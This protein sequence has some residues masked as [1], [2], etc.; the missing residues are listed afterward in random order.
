MAGTRRNAAQFFKS[1]AAKGARTWPGRKPT[2]KG[3][4]GSRA[5]H[6]AGYQYLGI[7]VAGMGN[8]ASVS[9]SDS[10]VPRS[11]LEARDATE[12]RHE[13][14]RGAPAM[15]EASP[16]TETTLETPDEAAPRSLAHR[17]S[18]Q[19]RVDNIVGRVLAHKD[20]SMLSPGGDRTIS[21][22][23]PVDQESAHSDTPQQK[24]ASPDDFIEAHHHE[25][26]VK[27][28]KDP[29]ATP[30]DSQPCEEFSP[31]QRGRDRGD[32]PGDSD[33]Q[34]RRQESRSCGESG[35]EV[36]SSQSYTDSGESGDNPSDDTFYEPEVSS[37]WVSGKSRGR[38][39]TLHGEVSTPNGSA[40]TLALPRLHRRRRLYHD[41][42][43]PFGMSGATARAKPPNILEPRLGTFGFQERRRRP[44][45]DTLV[46]T[47]LRQGRHVERG[48]G[49]VRE[50]PS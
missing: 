6:L 5:E 37:V 32:S 27:G 7:V 3:D 28:G 44:G 11:R 16:T 49:R 9:P 50:A 21:V 41:A 31:G 47:T 34:T 4:T 43:A 20:T 30:E 17:K 26:E 8:A 35:E 23:D 22:R 45:H 13:D 15:A 24:D 29:S 19:E 38:E 25:E 14:R 39:N 40:P 2:W 48:A 42:R 10:E 36:S 1:V 46:A 33:D 12:T 18:I